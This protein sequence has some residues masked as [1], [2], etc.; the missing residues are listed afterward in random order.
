MIVEDGACFLAR[1]PQF[2]EMIL[3]IAGNFPPLKYIILDYIV[4][5]AVVCAYTYAHANLCAAVFPLMLQRSAIS[6]CTFV[7]TF[8]STFARFA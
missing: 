7:S 8:V 3:I 2:I 5:Y 4:T 1:R 6:T